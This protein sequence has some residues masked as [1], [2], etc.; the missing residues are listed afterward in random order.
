MCRDHSIYVFPFPLLTEC[1][2]EVSPYAGW[3]MDMA[4][5]H[6]SSWYPV[7][8]CAGTSRFSPPWFSSWC[9]YTK[10]SSHCIQRWVTPWVDEQ[11]K[12]LSWLWTQ[13]HTS[14]ILL[15]FQNHLVDLDLWLSWMA[16]IIAIQRCWSPILMQS[17]LCEGEQSEQLFCFFDYSFWH[18]RCVSRLNA[19]ARSTLVYVAQRRCA[20]TSSVGK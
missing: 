4:L 1:A 11:H 15:G 13:T 17:T 10:E 16:S 8:K 19:F 2:V 7:S 9:W 5:L 20:K 14:E 3:V 6:H 18:C 12:T